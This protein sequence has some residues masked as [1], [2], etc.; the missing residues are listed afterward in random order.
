MTGRWL[1]VSKTITRIYDATGRL[2]TAR[3][4]LDLGKRSGQRGLVVEQSHEHTRVLEQSV[5]DHLDWLAGRL[6]PRR[7]D[8]VE[9][10]H[11]GDDQTAGPLIPRDPANPAEAE[12]TPTDDDL[13]RMEKDT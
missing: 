1:T 13:Y 4:V 11:G 9:A 2:L 8:E 10:A 3:D 7:A 12:M 5:A 6:T